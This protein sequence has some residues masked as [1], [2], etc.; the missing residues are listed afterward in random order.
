MTKSVKS[1]KLKLASV[2]IGAV[3][4]MEKDMVRKVIQQPISRAY[5]RVE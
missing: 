2:P 3:T 4:G 5:L 1:V